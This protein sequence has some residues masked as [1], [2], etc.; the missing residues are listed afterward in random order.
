[1]PKNHNFS[2][3]SKVIIINNPTFEGS[4]SI[5]RRY[6]G[7]HGVVNETGRNLLAVRFPNT[8]GL[9]WEWNCIKDKE[10]STTCPS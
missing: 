9:I 10:N 4:E 3:G 1:M 8:I 2:P 7:L 6:S 5:D